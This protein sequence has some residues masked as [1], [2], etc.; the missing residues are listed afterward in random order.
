MST[1][2]KRPSYEGS[3]FTEKVVAV[4]IAETFDLPAAA[5]LLRRAYEAIHTAELRHYQALAEREDERRASFIRAWTRGSALA[6]LEVL[7]PLVDRAVRAENPFRQGSGPYGSHIER[8][9]MMSV[10]ARVVHV[11]ERAYTDPC[12]ADPQGVMDTWDKD[13][14]PDASPDQIAEAAQ[15]V[16]R[17][18]TRRE[19]ARLAVLARDAKWTESGH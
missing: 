9:A 12:P 13:L 16:Q 15:V 18:Q 3:I 1:R 19:V 6:V 2:T 4:V 17:V 7:E 5:D 11:I 10:A 8:Q 14:T